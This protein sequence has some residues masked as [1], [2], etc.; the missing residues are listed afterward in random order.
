MKRIVFI[1]F[2]VLL[3]LSV[4][5]IAFAK[6]TIE[7][8]ATYS[9]NNDGLI[10]DTTHYVGATLNGRFDIG[11]KI[12]LFAS[13]DAG[14]LLSS[15]D[16][17]RSANFGTTILVN[18]AAISTDFAT[19]G[20]LGGFH[21]NGRIGTFT[22]TLGGPTTIYHNLYNRFVLTI[23]AFYDL[24]LSEKLSLYGEVEIPVA[25]YSAETKNYES[26]FITDSSLKDFDF[27]LSTLWLSYGI[28]YNFTPS[29]HVALQLNN[30]I[31]T[32]TTIT[33]LRLFTSVDLL[34]GFSF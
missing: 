25:I 26:A 24:A 30:N 8:G 34:F 23:G 20:L 22:T 9:N 3:V 28:R 6:N 4:S 10:N 21:Y 15:L 27:A 33:S 5:C 7:L 32:S 29:L 17:T 2:T 19:L 13:L 14:L 31:S 12:S 1:A 11:E 16:Q 18:Y